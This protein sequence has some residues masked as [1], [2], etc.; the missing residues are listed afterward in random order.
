M[1][2]DEKCKGCRF[3]SNVFGAFVCEVCIDHDEYELEEKC[4]DQ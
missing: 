3:E 4:E 1:K 2:I